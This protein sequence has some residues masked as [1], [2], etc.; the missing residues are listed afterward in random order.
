MELGFG[1]SQNWHMNKF[2]HNC[3]KRI[4]KKN[5]NHHPY[6]NQLYKLWY[7]YPYNGTLINIENDCSSSISNNTG[8][9][10]TCQAKQRHLDAIYYVLYER[11]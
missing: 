2:I 7:I 9:S 6:M 4:L 10:Q 8:E 1:F 3:K 11:S 5:P